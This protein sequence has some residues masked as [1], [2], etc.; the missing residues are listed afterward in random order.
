MKHIRVTAPHQ[1][2]WAGTVYGPGDTAEVP[3][4][5]AAEWIAAGWVTAQPP[6]KPKA[7]T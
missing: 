7:A 4:A 3:A 5:L 2:F 6:A 1:V